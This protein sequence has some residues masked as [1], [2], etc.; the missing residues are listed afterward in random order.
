MRPS[1]QTDDAASNSAALSLFELRRQLLRR[2]GA[3]S[4]RARGLRRKGD[5]MSA[6]RIAV[7]S[8]RLLLVA[9]TMGEN[10]RR[11]KKG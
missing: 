6:A 1:R 10:A 4:A 7:E 8:D 11:K 3:L 9:K 2:A 5:S